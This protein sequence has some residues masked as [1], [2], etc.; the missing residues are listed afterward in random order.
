MLLAFTGIIV[1]GASGMG[2][3]GP[4]WPALW[5]FQFFFSFMRFEPPHTCLDLVLLSYL[6]GHLLFFSWRLW[7]SFMSSR[8]PASLGLEALTHSGSSQMSEVRVGFAARMWLNLA[9]CWL[10]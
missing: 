6:L 5:L 10:A 7:V 9:T 2:V 4:L 8:N 3:F 1:M